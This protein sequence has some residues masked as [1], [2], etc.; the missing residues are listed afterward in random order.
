MQ[1]KSPYI[2]KGVCCFQDADSTLTADQLTNEELCQL[3]DK[4]LHI[5]ARPNFAAS[6]A[7][8]A[9]P[10]EHKIKRTVNKVVAQLQREKPLDSRMCFVCKFLLWWF[11]SEP[12]TLDML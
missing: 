4:H 12:F 11:W 8:P 7:G 1:S 5:D 3:L 9:A 6:D 10:I 2:G